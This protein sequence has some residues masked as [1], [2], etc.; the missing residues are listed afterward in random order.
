MEG[1]SKPLL[2]ESRW[3]KLPTPSSSAVIKNPSPR[4]GFITKSS[5]DPESS[6]PCL[7]LSD[8]HL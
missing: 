8:L 1:P 2:S 5:Q 3:G 7:C 6:L 4:T